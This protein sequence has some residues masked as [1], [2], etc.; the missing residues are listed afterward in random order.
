MGTF[1]RVRWL[2][3]P[4]LVIAFVAVAYHAWTTG[5]PDLGRTAPDTHRADTPA[6][7]EVPDAPNSDGPELD[8]VPLETA[9]EDAPAARE[10]GYASLAEEFSALMNLSVA[11]GGDDLV[12]AFAIHDG[13]A[14]IPPSEEALQAWIRENIAVPDIDV[15]L[16]RTRV[17]EC[18]GVPR[19]SFDTRRDILY[20]LAMQGDVQVQYL[21]A[22]LFPFGTHSHRRWLG[23]SSNGGNADA[24]VLLAQNLLAA[25]PLRY[26]RSKA[27]RLLSRA[28]ELGH[29]SAAYELV[30][31]EPEMTSEELRMAV[32]DEPL[33]E[34][35]TSPAE[36]N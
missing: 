9:A 29:E 33:P 18:R 17:E 12:R 36:S 21:L 14:G 4:V 30:V 6:R 11:S 5:S 15:E 23:E 27:Y 10:A 16:V 19:L 31:L 34:P 26:A 13:C 3:I 7:S 25:E 22:T 2:G 1:S 32:S 20:P 28:A 8:V 24:M 35:F